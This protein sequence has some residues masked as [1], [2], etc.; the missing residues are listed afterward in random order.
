MFLNKVQLIG[1]LTRDPEL[2]ALPSGQQVCSFSLATNETYKDKNTGNKVEKAEFHNCVAW[3]RTAEII[4]QYSKKGSGLYIEGKLQTRK[5]DKDGVTHYRTE[6]MVQ[7]V[8][9]GSKPRGEGGAERHPLESEFDQSNAQAAGDEVA[10]PDSE[11]NPEDI[12]F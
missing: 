4:A 12:P 11:I 8:Q 5:W 2:K 3:G 6:I 7:N 1:N 9:L 10:Y